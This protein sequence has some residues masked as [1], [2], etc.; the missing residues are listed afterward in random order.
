MKP[1]AVI[2]TN[3]LLSGVIPEFGRR[4]DVPVFVTL[5]GDDIFL[6]ALPA[7]DR[8]RSIELIRQNCANVAGYI[9]TSRYYADHM[10]SYLG[11]P[12]E[13]MHVVY[14][15][16]NLTG[17]GGARTVRTE[18]PLTIGYFAR[19]CPE[20]GFHHLVDA[21]IRLRRLPGAPAARLRASGWLGENAR[22]FFD[23]T[24]RADRGRRSCRRLRVR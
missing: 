17:H 22:P 19:I 12:R 3:A 11:L 16:I 13:R 6:D 5:Q 4:L 7:A 9:S 15:G 20:K 14:P 8:E 24:G 23:E 21:F 10:S 2:L 18:G 1:D